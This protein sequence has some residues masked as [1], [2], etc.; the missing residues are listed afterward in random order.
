MDEAGRKI[1]AQIIHLCEDS[2]QALDKV[3]KLKRYGSGD[4]S[5]VFFCRKV[6][7]AERDGMRVV[8]VESEVMDW[9]L[10]SPSY[11]RSLWG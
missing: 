2:E 8:L 10:S 3:K 6:E 5:L 1:F 4:A 9:I 11:A 7:P